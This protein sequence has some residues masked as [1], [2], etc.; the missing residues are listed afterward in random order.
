MSHY[1]PTGLCTNSATRWSVQKTKQSTIVDTKEPSLA[2]DYDCDLFD[3]IKLIL[4]EKWTLSA[5]K[6]HLCCE[7]LAHN[8]KFSIKNVSFV[9]LQMTLS[10]EKEIIAVIQSTG[11]G[12]IIH[13]SWITFGMHYFGMISTYIRENSYSDKKESNNKDE[14]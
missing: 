5:G 12:S 13:D 8:N 2:T 6:N 7:K 14:A 11:Y 1:I 4:V 10:V 9:L 3:W